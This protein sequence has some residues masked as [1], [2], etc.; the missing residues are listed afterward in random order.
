MKDYMNISSGVSILT[1]G[2]S[3]VDITNVLNI[4]ILVISIANILFVL[5]CRIYDRLKD[6]KL[7]KDEIKDTIKDVGDAK[8]E[9][10][11][12]VNKNKDEEE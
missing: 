4:V 6:G 9:I 12:L 2:V 1:G 5:A 8:S 11:H 7:T 10:E 3:L